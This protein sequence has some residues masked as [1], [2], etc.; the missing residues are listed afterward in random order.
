MA[1]GKSIT[2]FQRGQKFDHDFNIVKVGLE[3]PRELL[4]KRIDERMDK[5]IASGLFDEA[6][7]LYSKRDKQALQTVGYRE[8]FDFMEG[9]YDRAEAVRLLKRNS[10][11]Y[12]KRQ[13]TWFKKDA[14]ITWFDAR[15]PERV[16]NFVRAQIAS[17]NESRAEL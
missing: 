2:F 1:T 12:A 7:A 9:Q 16:I 13:L 15:Q 17:G 5:M 10:R 8:V 11:R 6:A 14:E 4:Y 3:L